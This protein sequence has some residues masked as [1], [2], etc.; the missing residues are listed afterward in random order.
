MAPRTTAPITLFVRLVQGGASSD[1]ALLV[2][3]ATEGVKLSAR[4]AEFVVRI[5]R[6]GPN[7]IRASFTNVR[8]GAVAMVQGN[9]ALK[10]IAADIDV[11]LGH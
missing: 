10:R 5:W 1:I 9:D 8:T 3:S 6:E 2:S 11:K 4:D 7:V